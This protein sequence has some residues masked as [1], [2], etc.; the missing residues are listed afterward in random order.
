M[1]GSESSYIP[2]D[3]R[4]GDDATFTHH[5]ANPHFV[6]WEVGEKYSLQRILGKGSYGQVA[7]AID[8]FVSS[9][10]VSFDCSE[11]LY[12]MK[13]HSGALHLEKRNLIGRC[14]VFL[15]T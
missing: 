2:G 1:R 3:K 13:M 5:Q 6:S 15:I 4:K 8:R 9:T 10:A 14:V 12:F 11:F 7:F